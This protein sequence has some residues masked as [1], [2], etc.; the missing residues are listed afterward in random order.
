[1][2]DLLRVYGDC[3]G[4]EAGAWNTSLQ[5][6]YLEY[7]FDRFLEENFPVE[8][9]DAILNIG[10]GAGYWDR[11]LS[12]KVPKGS[13]SSID[14]DAACAEN[15]KACLENERNPNQVTVLCGDAITYEL[16]RKYDLVTI[17]GSSAAESGEVER[18]VSKAFSLLN[19]NGAFYLQM[20]HRG[21]AFDIDHWA[22]GQGARIEKRLTDDTYDIR[23]AYYKIVKE[24]Q[25]NDGKA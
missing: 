22:L 23:C 19:E 15:L 1:M 18:I 12:Y 16:D 11:Y 17:V 20:L 9:T 5:N 25:E 21:T 7:M 24:G 3:W 6:K 8:E 14:I 4:G 2:T 13:L 10:I